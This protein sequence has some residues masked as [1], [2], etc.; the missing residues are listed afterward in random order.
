MGKVWGKIM[1][2]SMID[3]LGP[4]AS[5]K[6]LENCSIEFFVYGLSDN[7]INTT[8]YKDNNNYKIKIDYEVPK[9]S[10]DEFFNVIENEIEG[11]KKWI[12]N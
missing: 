10:I 7:Y 5:P 6:Y 8:L 3:W 4:E 12:K 11:D 9:K 1:D 2:E